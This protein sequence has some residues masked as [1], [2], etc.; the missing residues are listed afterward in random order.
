MSIKDD[1]EKKRRKI[2]EQELRG[3]DE[4]ACEQLPEEDEE[5]EQWQRSS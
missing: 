3:Y 1:W 2:W 5:P 4:D